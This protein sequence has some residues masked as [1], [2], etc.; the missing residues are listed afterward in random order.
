MYIMYSK[1]GQEHNNI[2]NTREGIFSRTG[3]NIVM[4]P[5]LKHIIVNEQTAACVCG[6][7]FLIF[8]FFKKL[9]TATRT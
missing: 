1:R 8:L 6:I 9:Y 4:N 3:P 7:Y 5:I 2:Y